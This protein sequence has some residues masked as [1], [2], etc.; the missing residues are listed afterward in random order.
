MGAW[1]IAGF[2]GVFCILR[3]H[4]YRV[5]DSSEDSSSTES[6]SSSNQY[7]DEQ[8]VASTSKEK[9]KPFRPSKELFSIQELIS[10][11]SDITRAYQV[12]PLND[13]IPLES[14]PLQ[15]VNTPYPST[16]YES[17]AKQPYSNLILLPPQ[18]VM[19]EPQK[20]ENDNESGSEEETTNAPLS[21][22]LQ[23]PND[24]K[25]SGTAFYNYQVEPSNL[26]SILQIPR[27]RKRRC[28]TINTNTSMTINTSKTIITNM[29]S[30]MLTITNTPTTKRASTSTSTKK[31][32]NTITKQNIITVTKTII[33]TM[34]RVN[35]GTITNRITSTRTNMM[36]ST[37]TKTIT[38][39]SIST[40]ESTIIN[41]TTI[42][43]TSI[44]MDI[45]TKGITGINIKEGPSIS[46]VISTKLC[47]NSTELKLGRLRL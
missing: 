1:V 15:V 46:T 34:R 21:L 24:Q 26:K 11:A 25:A 43:S 6:P 28:I 44:S 36:R 16:G 9:S 30:I 22:K 47:G 4:P 31:S 20:A 19:Y 32:T 7:Y 23:T 18:Y 8:L 29:S 39:T 12:V 2:I 5:E 41:I 14:V 38:N 45:I 37:I 35:T 27:R 33:T 13:H 10:D 3:A 40:R 42:T 17:S